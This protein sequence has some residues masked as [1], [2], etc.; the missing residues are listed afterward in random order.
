MNNDL[1]C[2]KYGGDGDNGEAMMYL[3][4]CQFAREKRPA[5]FCAS[6][7]AG[8]HTAILYQACGERI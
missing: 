2:I 1:L 4:D 3:L 5:R 7:D 8:D 6:C